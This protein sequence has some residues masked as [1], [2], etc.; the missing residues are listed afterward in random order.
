LIICKVIN[1]FTINIEIQSGII[2]EDELSDYS[3]IT[4]RV[5]QSDFIVA[6]GEMRIFI[7][8]QHID[9]N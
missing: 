1:K 9:E 3:I 8:N 6:E 2:I 7:E 5:F 4:G